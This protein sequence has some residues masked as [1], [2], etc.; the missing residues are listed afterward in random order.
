MEGENTR[1][2]EGDGRFL[3]VCVVLN[4]EKSSALEERV[5][6]L[7]GEFFIKSLCQWVGGWVCACVSSALGGILVRWLEGGREGAI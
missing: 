1:G 5:F 7:F 2:E 6:N 3:R 4:D